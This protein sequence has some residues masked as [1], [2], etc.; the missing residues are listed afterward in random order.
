MGTLSKYASISV[1]IPAKNEAGGIANVVDS[2]KPLADEILVIDG[3]STDETAELAKA[4]GATVYQ[5][6]GRGKGAAYIL[7]IEKATGQIVVFMDADGSHDAADIPKLVAPILEGEADLVI[8]SRHR[9]G[10]DEWQGDLNTFLRSIGSGIL[11]LAMNYRWGTQITDCLNGFR[12]IRRD[13]ALNLTFHAMDFD[14]EQHMIA[15]CIKH[16]YRHTEIATHEYTRKWG[17]SKLPTYKKAYLF[18]WRLFLDI[19]RSPVRQSMAKGHIQSQLVLA[20][21][22]ESDSLS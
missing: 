21:F 1:V 13:V 15:Q 18:F 7:G 12:A 16:G 22:E 20:G 5:D 10:S 9:G 2:V 19:V 8:G 4:A 3:H 17:H 14:I 6:N 11:S